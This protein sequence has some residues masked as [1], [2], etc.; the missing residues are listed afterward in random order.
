M[1]LLPPQ[2]PAL[3]GDAPAAAP[4]RVMSRKSQSFAERV[5]TVRV[6]TAPIT[7]D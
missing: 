2:F 1:P 3:V 5:A 4:A 6:R 7:L